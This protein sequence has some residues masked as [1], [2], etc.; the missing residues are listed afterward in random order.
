MFRLNSQGGFRRR[1][2]DNLSQKGIHM[3]HALLGACALAF[4]FSVSG[5]NSASTDVALA[6]NALATLAKY[7]IPTACSIIAVAEG[8][9]SQLRSDLS[10][11]EIADETKAANAVNII[12]NAPP[13][14]V[15]A[16]FGT[17]VQA[18]VA[19]QNDTTVPTPATPTPTPTA[20]SN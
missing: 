18:W 13:T 6:N 14:N 10:A 1:R 2:D 20:T 12:C 11:A 5:C 8:Y 15:E 3:K 16:A 17:L 7:D 9:F 19:I 4:V